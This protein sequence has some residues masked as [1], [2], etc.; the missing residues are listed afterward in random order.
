MGNHENGKS[1]CLIIEFMASD[2][3]QFCHAT[4]NLTSPQ[5]RE[6]IVNVTNVK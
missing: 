6:E 5:Q 3:H 2:F 1:K 4:R